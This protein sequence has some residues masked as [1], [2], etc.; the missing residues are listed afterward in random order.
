MSIK[1][2]GDQIGMRI[3]NPLNIHHASSLTSCV[4][5][6]ALPLSILV[7]NDMLDSELAN[8]N[9]AIANIL[10]IFSIH[11]VSAGRAATLFGVFA[12]RCALGASVVLQA[13]RVSELF[14]ARKLIERE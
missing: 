2:H 3:T 1:A 11:P 8:V 4:A 13:G 6:S 7:V 12:W 10:R 14:A 9:W 5:N